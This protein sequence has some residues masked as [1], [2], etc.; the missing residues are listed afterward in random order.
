[1]KRVTMPK[2]LEPPFSD[3]H[4]ARFSVDDAVVMVP[5]ARTTWYDATFSAVKPALVAK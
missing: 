3:I 4:K 5:F 2:L 1:M